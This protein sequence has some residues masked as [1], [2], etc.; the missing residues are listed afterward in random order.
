MQ[1]LRGMKTREN[2]SWTDKMV[3]TMNVEKKGGLWQVTSG[4]AS[5]P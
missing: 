1:V 2:V 3:H 4:K 5:A